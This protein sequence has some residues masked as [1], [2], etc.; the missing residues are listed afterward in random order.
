MGDSFCKV[1]CM[2]IAFIHKISTNYTEH[3]SRLTILNCGNRWEG[4]EK[5][6][7][8]IA[9]TKIEQRLLVQRLLVQRLLL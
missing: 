3:E 2:K 7:V 5:A 9:C 6:F 4:W 1:A 8:K